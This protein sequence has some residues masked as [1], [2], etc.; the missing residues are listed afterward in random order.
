M[1]RRRMKFYNNISRNTI[2]FII[3][4]VVKMFGHIRQSLE[5]DTRVRNET[6]R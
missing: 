2:I 1:T 5:G 4:F 6:G 3:R